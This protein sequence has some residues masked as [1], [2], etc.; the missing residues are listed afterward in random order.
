M[1]PHI[2]I[3]DMGPAFVWRSRPT[4]LPNSIPPPSFYQVGPAEV[5][6]ASHF[7]VPELQSTPFHFI[8]DLAFILN[9]GPGREP[10]VVDPPIGT[11]FPHWI[12][13]EISSL[14]V[15]K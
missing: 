9:P 13:D 6:T 4:T 2:E 15:P 5:T 3:R 7:P 1:L 11:S 12:G 14:P 8:F 10:G